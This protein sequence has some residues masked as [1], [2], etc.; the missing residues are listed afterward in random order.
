ML[1]RLP[2]MLVVAAATAGAKP[3]TRPEPA[4]L[5]DAEG[6]ARAG[7]AL[8]ALIE[9]SEGTIT[10]ALEPQ[11]APLSVQA[12]V[13]LATG[14]REWTNPKGEKVK[15][16]LYDGTI[17][18]RAIPGF[19]LQGGDPKGNGTGGP[20]FT[21]A[22][23]STTPGQRALHFRA[24]AVGLSKTPDPAAPGSQFFILVGDAPWLDGRFTQIGHVIGG[25][26]VAEAVANRPRGPQDRPLDPVGITHLRITDKPPRN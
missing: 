20:G 13:G 24:G 9:T 26:E 7:T 17:F 25:L 11:A 6:E 4:P 14:Q 23:E 15:T 22:D 5:A 3:R 19:V 12:F 2:W 18:H 8:Y 16:P 1:R 21:T 10:V